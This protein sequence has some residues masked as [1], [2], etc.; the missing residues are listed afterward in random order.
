MSELNGNPFKGEIDQGGSSFMKPFQA[1]LLAH[2]LTSPKQLDGEGGGGG[3]DVVL[4]NVT[5]TR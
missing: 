1:S 3:G 5:R 2:G 4:S